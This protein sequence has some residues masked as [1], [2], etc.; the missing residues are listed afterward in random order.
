MSKLK[1]WSISQDDK[2]IEI[3]I[4]SLNILNRIFQDSSLKLDLQHFVG[5][6]L[7]T[8]IVG[9]SHNDWSVRNSS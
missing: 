3:R 6:G 2:M 1:D 7:M 8:A 9:F 4:H 5:N